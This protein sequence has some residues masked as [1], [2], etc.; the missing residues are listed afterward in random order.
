MEPI[1]HNTTN[2]SCIV[3]IVKDITVLTTN[4]QE[5][6]MDTSF[7]DE[8]DVDDG[9]SSGE[10]SQ[11]FSFTTAMDL[12]KNLTETFD[13]VSIEP[14]VANSTTDFAARESTANTVTSSDS[15]SVIDRIARF[16][17]VNAMNKAKPPLPLKKQPN[18][19][20]RNALSVYLR[21]RPPTVNPTEKVGKAKKSNDVATNTIDVLPAVRPNVHP[22]LVRTYAPAQSNTSKVNSHR[23]NDPAS[24]AKEYEFHQVLEPETT[25]KS[26]YSTVA[27]PLVQSLFDSITSKKDQKVK[28]HKRN[29]TFHFET[30]L[31]FSYG[32]TKI[33]RAHV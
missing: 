1:K 24:C 3:A 23:D 31:L 15:N 18:P 20:P 12:R 32:V 5:P 4:T 19:V 13:K 14:A 30:A 22:T 10:S 28:G 21:I 27:A 7:V 17:H 9:R 6:N 26:V 11:S 8:S 16:E 25:Q 29:T 2:K 33:G